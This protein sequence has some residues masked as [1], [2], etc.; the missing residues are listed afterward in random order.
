MP[1]NNI[2]PLSEFRRAAYRALR[3]SNKN[4]MDL[5][6]PQ[7][8]FYLLTNLVTHGCPKSTLDQILQT[9]AN[10]PIDSTSTEIVTAT[11]A[12]RKSVTFKLPVPETVTP[13]PAPIPETVTPR[14]SP[15]PETVTPDPTQIVDSVAAEPMLIW[16]TVTLC[17]T[18]SPMPR[19]VN[20]KMPTISQPYNTKE[21][22]NPAYYSNR[23]PPVSWPRRLELFPSRQRSRVATAAAAAA[24]ASIAAQ[25]RQDAL[26]A[27]AHKRAPLLRL[28]AKDIQNDQQR[29]KRNKNLLSSALSIIREM[30][31]AYLEILCYAIHDQVTQ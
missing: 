22:N 16:E 20:L 18:P 1:K 19:T 25:V 14:P 27:L 23:M 17:P 11:P 7:V 30:D 13:R 29:V 10:K 9:Q 15:V 8:E 28:A 12:T 5:K 3:E 2:T 4:K 6:D 31:P 24:T 26:D 21:T